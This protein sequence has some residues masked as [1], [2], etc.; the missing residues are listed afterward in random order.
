MSIL[1]IDVG[2]SGLRA[3]VVRPDATIAAEQHREL[4]PDTPAPG[5][6]SSTPPAWPRSR[7]TWPG[8]C[9]PRAAR[10]TRSASPTSG[11]RRSCGIARPASRSG[12]ALGWQDLRTIGTCLVLQADGLGVAPNASATKVAH[13]LDEADPDRARDLCVGTV[14]T[15]LDVAPLRRSAARHRRH[16]RRRHRRCSAATAATGTTACSTRSAST[17]RRCPP[18][19]TRAG[20][21][22]PATALEGAP[23]IASLVG[24]Q[25]S[26]LIGQGGVQRG[27]AKITFGTGGMLDVHLGEERP[28]FERAGRRRLLPDRGLAARRRHHLGRRGGD[29]LRGH[30]R[31]V[32]PRRPRP[33][34]H[35]RREPRRRQPVRDVRRRRVRAGAARSRHAPLGL[36]RSRH[37]ARPHPWERAAADRAGGPRRRRPARR[38]SRRGGRARHRPHASRRCGSTA[39]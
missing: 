4:L 16:Q 35:R 38:R 2:T 15:W 27:L 23:P 28:R 22:A 8:R 9:W 3:A 39:A 36:R 6:S 5:W 32:A 10:S 33:H 12:P 31:R 21:S 37:A 25:Q 17:A 13:L 30:E 14:D 11:R 20:C 29:A 34:R 26:S 24:D 19:S 18:S 7:S 1:V